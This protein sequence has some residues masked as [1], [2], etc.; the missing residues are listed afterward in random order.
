VAGSPECRPSIN[1]VPS[2]CCETGSGCNGG[3]IPR[4]P[5]GSPYSRPRCLSMHLRPLGI[6]SRFADRGLSVFV[7]EAVKGTH[8]RFEQGPLATRNLLAS[9]GANP[10]PLCAGLP[11]A[12]S[13]KRRS[14]LPQA[15][16]I[17]HHS[18]RRTV[19]QQL[20]LWIAATRIR[21]PERQRD[22]ARRFSKRRAARKAAKAAWK[23]YSGLI[24]GVVQW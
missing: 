12:Q 5:A 8:S 19:L 13:I 18:R 20:W 15:G 21:E 10:H 24:A 4:D 14:Q 7:I 17:L 3:S 16:S 23:G 2:N 9:A 1:D 22:A 11:P 6:R